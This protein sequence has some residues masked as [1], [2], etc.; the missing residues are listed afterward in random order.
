MSTTSPEIRYFR[1]ANETLR[2]SLTP[3]F[4]PIVPDI[5][6]LRC[7]E[8]DSDFGLNAGKIGTASNIYFAR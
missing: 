2:V 3:C 7:N 4:S 8:L 6:E 1:D 5:P